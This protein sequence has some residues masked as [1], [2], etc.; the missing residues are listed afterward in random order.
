MIEILIWYFVIE[1]CSVISTMFGNKGLTD[2][3]ENISS[4]ISFMNIVMFF[5]A[6]LLVISTGIVIIMGK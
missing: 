2:V 4:T 5:V 6:F 1:F 3:F